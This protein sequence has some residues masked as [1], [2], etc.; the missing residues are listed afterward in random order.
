MNCRPGLPGLTPDLPRGLPPAGQTPRE[1]IAASRQCRPRS[2]E[3]R[4]VVCH[5]AEACRLPAYGLQPRIMAQRDQLSHTA[6][7]LHLQQ[8]YL[9]KSG[10]RETTLLPRR[11]P[12]VPDL[13]FEQSYLSSIRPF[14]HVERSFGET[15]AE[16][17]KGKGKGVDVP[18]DVQVSTEVITIRWGRVAWITTRDQIISPLLQGAV[19]YAVSR[20]YSA[21][22]C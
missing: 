17:A 11:V 14:V 20:M 5:N 3:R 18:G 19:R 8:E 15:A 1:C 7:A 6:H 12:A 22:P 10:H 13:R 4:G 21:P 9:E 16:D 2:T